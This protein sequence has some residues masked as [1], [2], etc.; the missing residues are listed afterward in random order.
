MKSKFRIFFLILI[1]SSL[2]TIF[3]IERSKIY[4]GYSEGYTGGSI[5][6]YTSTSTITTISTR[7]ETTIYPT[8]YTTITRFTTVT[9]S[10]TITTQS[11]LIKKTFETVLIGKAGSSAL[12][13][14]FGWYRYLFESA[15]DTEHMPIPYTVY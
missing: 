5:E 3:I 15:N 11:E 13:F 14:C 8:V 4:G 7:A 6:T 2:F 9:G 10:L 12:P 1:I